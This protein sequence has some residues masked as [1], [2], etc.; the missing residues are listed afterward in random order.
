MGIPTPHIRLVASVLYT[1]LSLTIATL[2]RDHDPKT[3]PRMSF[4]VGQAQALSLLPLSGTEL[5]SGNST[6]GN[7]RRRTVLVAMEPLHNSANRSKSPPG[8]RLARPLGNVIYIM[9]SPTSREECTRPTDILLNHQE[10]GRR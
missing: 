7:D 8:W 4:D 9:V 2:E 10:D 5:Y 1:L 3:G 6:G